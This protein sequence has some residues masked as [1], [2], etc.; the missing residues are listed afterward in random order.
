MIREAIDYVEAKLVNASAPVFTDPATL[1]ADPL[2]VLVGIP[3]LAN[4]GFG[5]TYTVTVPIHVISSEALTADLRDQLFDLAL[6]CADALGIKEFELD[7]WTTSTN[8]SELPAYTLQTTVT[9][10]A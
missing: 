3:E 7:G 9:L 4:R 5:G 1:Y 2:A 8:Q 10:E 6:E